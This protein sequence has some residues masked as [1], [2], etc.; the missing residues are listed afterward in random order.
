MPYKIFL[1]PFAFFESRFF[2]TT[3]SAFR[4]IHSSA[5]TRMKV[6]IQIISTPSAQTAASVGL[7]FA[8]C[9]YLIN[10]GESTQRLMGQ[11]RFRLSKLKCIFATNIS[12][13]S[14]GGIPGLLLS[15]SEIEPKL[16]DL[17]LLGPKNLTSFLSG[18][19]IFVRRPDMPLSLTEIS[20]SKIV[21]SDENL[22]VQA[23]V[24]YP[25]GELL[26]D[27]DIQLPTKVKRP[28]ILQEMFKIANDD[29]AASVGE[30]LFPP[31]A[32]SL[33]FNLPPVPGKMDG[34]KANE[35]G[36][37]GKD[38]KKLIVGESVIST[39][40]TVVTPEMCVEP[41]R[42]GQTIVYADCNRICYLGNFLGND[43][44]KSVVDGAKLT[45]TTVIHSCSAD[46]ARSE[47]YVN[48]IK[49]FPDNSRHILLCNG[50]HSTNDV[51]YSSDDL[52]HVLSE[53]SDLFRV[54][55][56]EDEFEGDGLSLTELQNCSLGSHKISIQLEPKPALYETFKSKLDL[57]RC[58]EFENMVTELQQAISHTSECAAADEVQYIISLGTGSC[59]PGKLR[60]GICF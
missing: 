18:S 59:M 54:I 53:I 17:R 39:M 51:F 29:R 10:C 36:V 24:V 12:W 26:V 45:K 43:L 6:D 48:W 31:S 21:Y 46:V 5:I 33:I 28:K 34:K 4:A 22:S 1:S 15:V 11:S 32:V 8:N 56:H 20:D 2:T 49:S 41:Q 47:D 50:F 30:A 23:A 40:G 16:Q 3:I 19:S 42:P 52:V 13:D 37:S 38:R 44:M 7:N 27:N 60:N 57:T 9:S 58:E 14:V 25:D 55:K 35:L